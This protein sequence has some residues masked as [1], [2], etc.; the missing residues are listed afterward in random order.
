MKAV[1]VHEG[2]PFRKTHDLFELARA[3][4][5]TRPELAALAAPLAE[6]TPWH[7]FGRYPGPFGFETL[8]DEA[9]V[10]AARPVIDAF[11]AAVRSLI[12]GG[13]PPAPAE[14]EC[15]GAGDHH[16]PLPSRRR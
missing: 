12:A 11:S 4:A 3:V 7:L 6:P 13:R 1:L 5:D 16:D 8:P 9:D 2:R 15:R 10:R 14:K